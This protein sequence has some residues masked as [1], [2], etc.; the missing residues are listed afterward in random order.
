MFIIFSR[1]ADPGGLPPDLDPPSTGSESYTR[2]TTRIQSKIL[3]HGPDPDLNP[4]KFG[5]PDPDPTKTPGSR[6]TTLIFSFALCLLHI[7]LW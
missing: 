4:I 1:A 5:K 3:E 6:F 2:K 7:S